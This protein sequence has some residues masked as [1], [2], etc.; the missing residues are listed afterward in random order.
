MYWIQEVRTKVE[1]SS[2][3]VVLPYAIG[4]PKYLPKLEEI[5]IKA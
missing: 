4:I 1:S 3:A 5:L 2:K